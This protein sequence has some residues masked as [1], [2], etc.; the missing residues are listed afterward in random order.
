MKQK[1][2]IVG[3]VAGGATAAARLRRISEDAEVIMVERGEH[4]SFANCG[5]PYYIGE[6]IK[7]RSKLLVQTVE[8][9]SERFKLDIRN[10]SEVMSINPV[11]KT[12]SIKNLQTGEV[13]DE[14]YDKLLLSPGAKPIVPPI[15]GLNENETLF[16]LRNIPDTDKIKNYVDQQNPQKAVVVGGGF[17]GIEMAENL[18]DR[19]MEVTLVEMANQI[20]API[21][22]EMAS[23]LHNHLKDKGVNLI[24]EKAVQSFADKGKK[25][26]L[27]DGT[28]FT[29]DMT[30]FSIGVRPENELAKN[31]GLELGE[32]GGI[33]VNEYLQTSN[34][35][36]YA[37]G[38]AIE[39]VDYINGQKAM[40]PLAGPANRQGRIAANN[41]MG[42]QE[43]YQGTL[44]TSI[45]KVFDFT[46]AATGNNEK[47]LKRLGVPYE[48]V[49]I[50]PNSHAGYY[51]GAA[52]IALKLVFDQVTGKIFGAQAVG[53][54]GADKRIDVI[55]TAIKGGL[56]VED[57]TNL[58]LSYAPP[59]SS[60]K[61]PVNMAG[62]V[63]TN[64]LDGELAHVQWHEI[65]QI[66]SEGGVLIDVREPVERE[67]G[68]IDGSIN[69]PLNELRDRLEELPKDKTIHVSCQV[70]LRGY[71]AT[72]ILKNHGF[73]VKNVDGGWKTYSGV[74][75]SNIKQ[76][77]DT[78]DR[79]E[80]ESEPKVEEN[81]TEI[82]VAKVVDV[83]GLTCPMPIIKLKKGIDSV[84]SGQVIE[85]QATDK[86]ALNDLPAWANN[87]GHTI[88]NTEN[89]G[90]LI[91]FWVQKN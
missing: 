32:R 76:A 27:S 30:I 71:L 91:K 66:V 46:V 2:I 57:L 83:A 18:V 5:L 60:A 88:L 85:L 41:M 89:E 34:H 79:G 11:A 24:L 59:F 15:P 17:I 44:G 9:M 56:T 69:I 72:R 16:T 80:V 45:A 7:D 49:H 6:T 31:A 84:E 21:D 63:A 33:V 12:V 73:N 61:D 87:A 58:E 81:M 8:G 68:Y 48:V 53:M 62:Y 37:V 86:G 40:I 19:G 55:A 26:I 75:G 38:D 65:D 14:T 1:V 51:P 3:G 13:Y 47:T 22:F 10:L 23:I 43:K 35:D 82:K 78:N 42:K 64:L 52:P 67:F 50:H 4:I 90:S 20:M 70:G 74:F 25:V 29:T 54:D 39:V 77:F 36:I 28:E